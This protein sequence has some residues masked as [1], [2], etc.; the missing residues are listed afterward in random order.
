[1]LRLQCFIIL[2]LIANSSCD[3]KLWTYTAN[4]R[5]KQ[6]WVEGKH[7]EHCN[8]LIFPETGS[9]NDFVIGQ[10]SVKSV[11][12]PRRGDVGLYPGSRIIFDENSPDLINCV[13]LKP[14]DAK[15]WDDIRGWKDLE[16]PG[17]PA[18]PY[19]ERLPSRYDD[20]IFNDV[21]DSRILSMLRDS[22]VKSII[23]LKGNSE[24]LMLSHLYSN[25][26]FIITND[27]CSDPT[28]CSLSQME[29][30]YQ[31]DVCYYAS[32]VEPSHNCE[33][34]IVP[35]GFCQIPRCGASILIRNLKVGFR[36][37][38]I[39]NKLR[40]YKSF[41]HASK[42]PGSRH[43][44]VVFAEVNFT[45]V[46]LD[47]ARDFYNLL[48]ADNSY[49]SG[50]I[51]LLLS[52]PP[53]SDSYKIVKN[54]ISMTLGSLLVAILVFGLL[55]L[56][57]SPVFGNVD[58]RTR[59]LG[60]RPLATYVLRYDNIHDRG[61]TIDTV[62]SRSSSLVNLNHSFENPV[63]DQSTSRS[64]SNE[65][66]ASVKQLENPSGTNQAQAVEEQYE[67]DKVP[68]AEEVQDEAKV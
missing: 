65:T 26:K 4:V 8:G 9:L 7:Q 59:L 18:I 62:P 31:N 64:T 33:S 2:L 15:F 61:C 6:N 43:V 60:S 44:Q 46:S 30:P 52:G 13:K 23:V 21:M 22:P 20:V 57:F 17:N 5:D 27:T 10:I 24:D 51:Q 11:V 32:M 14:V 40:D 39:K 19:H 66:L 29:V 49:Y 55:L 53:L 41:T 37:E 50:D 38:R 58:I 36:L 16:D 1:M 12:L 67:C 63:Y 3:R 56:V 25:G 68:C 42:V 45:A 54:A 47:E 28:G 34:P 35:W 48:Q